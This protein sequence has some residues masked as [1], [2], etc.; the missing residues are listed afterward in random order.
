MHMASSL[1]K[2]WFDTKVVCPSLGTPTTD[3]TAWTLKSD[4]SGAFEKYLEKDEIHRLQQLRS[5][6]FGWPLFLACKLNLCLF[7]FWWLMMSF[8]GA[9]FA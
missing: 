2:Q 1:Y 8:A 6:I 3:P 5:C 7:V 4:F 9:Y